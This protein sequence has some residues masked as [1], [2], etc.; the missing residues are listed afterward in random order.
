M[1]VI[2]DGDAIDYLIETH[3]RAVQRPFRNC[4]PRDLLLQVRNFCTY[5]RLPR[6]MSCEA[7]DFAV[8]NYFSVL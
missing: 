2:Y 8:E 1:G 5:K 3:Y 6:K 7:F 4:Q